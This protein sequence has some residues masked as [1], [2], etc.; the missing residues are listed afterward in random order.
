[1]K[2]LNDTLQPFK[3]RGV[4][5]RV[6]TGNKLFLT[7]A[8]G[9][10]RFELDLIKKNKPQLLLFVP[11]GKSYCMSQIL[12]AIKRI[13]NHASLLV[14]D[15]GYDQHGADLRAL[16]IGYGYLEYIP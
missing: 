11:K 14:I 10:S 13:I 16:P 5:L 1:M 6:E 7:G 3:G 4:S 2:Q 8:D 9:L 15:G 12:T